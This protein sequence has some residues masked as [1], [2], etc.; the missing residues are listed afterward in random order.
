M[1]SRMEKNL[2]LLSE[3]IRDMY[4]QFKHPEGV[5]ALRKTLVP[6]VKEKVRSVVFPLPQGEE[7]EERPGKYPCLREL[8]T[9]PFAHFDQTNYPKQVLAV[10]LRLWFGK[11][12]GLKK[13]ITLLESFFQL[14][15]EFV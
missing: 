11:L 13:P 6:D 4:T 1:Y 10:T 9:L 7:V 15:V 8:V 3:T 2:Q 12:Q 14:K 5:V